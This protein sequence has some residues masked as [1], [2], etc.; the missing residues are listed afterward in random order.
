MTNIYLTSDC[1]FDH[2]NIIVYC[3]RPFL[4]EGDI[5]PGT[6][7]W[8]NDKVKKDRAN[9]MNETIIER[10]NKTVKNT[11][12]VYNLGDFCYCRGGRTAEYWERRLNGKII[13]I[14]G[15]HDKNNGI[16][17]L[18]QSA[19]LEFG[20]RQFLVQHI[21]PTMYQE[22]PDF[23]DA[24]LCGHVHEKWKHAFI[25]DVPII[26][27]GLDQ[28]EFTPIKINLVLKYLGKINKG[29]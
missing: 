3:G 28:W 1:H 16:K 25:K 13:H 4:K 20:E 6:Q 27:V 2:A 19:I 14:A 8:V 23:V 18:V 21:P 24:V 11:D 15:N 9:W 26:N 7:Q 10:W 29:K 5:I 17:T 22:I 12:I